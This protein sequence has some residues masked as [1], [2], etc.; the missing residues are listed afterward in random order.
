MT[1]R[2]AERPARPYVSV[3]NAL[4]QV[5]DV[6]ARVTSSYALRARDPVWLAEMARG[7]AGCVHVSVP[8]GALKKDTFVWRQWMI[9]LDKFRSRAW[10]PDRNDLDSASSLTHSFLRNI[11]AWCAPKL[12]RSPRVHSI[13]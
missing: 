1:A 11:V 13:T 8:E 5:A 4:A 10:R 7:V 12:L 2:F 3:D 6:L 9:H